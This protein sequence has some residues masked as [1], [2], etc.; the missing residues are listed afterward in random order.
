MKTIKSIFVFVANIFIALYIALFR[1][2]LSIVTLPKTVYVQCRTANRFSKQYS[3][4]Y[5]AK[6]GFKNNLKA[7]ACRTLGLLAPVLYVG[8]LAAMGYGIYKKPGKALGALIGGTLV[9]SVMAFIA[10]ERK[11]NGL[12]AV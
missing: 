2:V 6:G 4:E 12:L 11:D 5:R 10:S 8:Y 7:F 3:A 9:S 1:L